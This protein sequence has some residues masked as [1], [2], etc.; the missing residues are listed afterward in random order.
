MPKNQIVPTH[1]LPSR[2]VKVILRGD[3]L[4]KLERLRTEEGPKP[5]LSTLVNAAVITAFQYQ[6]CFLSDVETQSARQQS[7]AV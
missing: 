5:S 6:D 1:L 7:R 4:A 3:L 2:S